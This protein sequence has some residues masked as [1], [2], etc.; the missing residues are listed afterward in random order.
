MDYDIG[1]ILRKWKHKPGEVTVRRITG[2]DGRAKIQM[3]L[4]LGLLQMEQDGRPDG[5]R[6]HGCESLLKYHLGRLEQYKTANGVEIGF[7]L[8]KKQCQGLRE[9]SVMYYYRYLSLFIMGQYRKVVRDTNH[10]LAV[11]D[12]CR[13]FAGRKVDR[14]T[15]EQY[16]PYV[17][18]M[19]TRAQAQLEIEGNNLKDAM[20]TC[21]TG[22]EKI[23]SFFKQMS[24][25]E[26]AENSSE[27]AILQALGEDIKGKL[28]T[29]PAEVL[30]ADLVKAI[31]LEQYEKAAELRDRLRH[32]KGPDCQPFQN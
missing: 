29:N 4:D 24:R 6:P 32:L 13:K 5:A 12:L 23:A 15:L 9:E 2:S 7:E 17:L 8:T 28:P 20:R 25:P 21:E 27:L 18:M 22:I 11:F 1:P 14:Y 30:N 26:L 19:N 31:D 16:R 3:R 10:N